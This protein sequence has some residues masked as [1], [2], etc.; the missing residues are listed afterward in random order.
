MIA[1]L[2]G[3]PPAAGVQGG[4]VPTVKRFLSIKQE[5][6]DAEKLG[7]LLKKDADTLETALFDAV[8]TNGG[9][10]EADEFV[11]SI[12][13]EP[14]DRFPPWRQICEEIVQ[15][16]GLSPDVVANKLKSLPVRRKLVIA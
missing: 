1:T 8:E 13:D 11:L 14:G 2:N 16:H 5:Q 10:M 4:L 12:E 15:E 6:R 7:R 3:S 9:M